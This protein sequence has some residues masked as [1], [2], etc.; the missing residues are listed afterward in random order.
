MQPEHCMY[1]ELVKNKTKQEH[2]H[3]C[4][5]SSLSNGDCYPPYKP[6]DLSE[7]N[8]DQ[9]KWNER[10]NPT[11]SFF[12]LHTCWWCASPPH[13]HITYTRFKKFKSSEAKRK[14]PAKLYCYKGSSRVWEVHTGEL[15]LPW[16]HS[17]VQPVCATCDPVTRQAK[18]NG[19][20]RDL[21]NKKYSII[22]FPEKS[23]QELSPVSILGLR[24]TTSESCPSLPASLSSLMPEFVSLFFLKTVL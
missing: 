16:L 7:F 6:D 21:S 19:S 1:N 20:L 10:T 24:V 2:T 15:S 18:Q 17:K 14:R 3:T 8:R 23:R 4:K 22:F 13:H 11:K 12:Y 9:V 5:K